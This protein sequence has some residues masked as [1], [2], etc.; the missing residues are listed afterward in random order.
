MNGMNPSD[1]WFDEMP[2]K[3]EVYVWAIQHPERWDLKAPEGLKDDP[4]VQEWL[5]TAKAKVIEQMKKELE[6]GKI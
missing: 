3:Q 5:K 4:K 1:I 2:T 6:E